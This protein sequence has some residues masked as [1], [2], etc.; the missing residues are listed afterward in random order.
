MSDESEFDLFELETAKL[1]LEAECVLGAEM[2]RAA[3][4]KACELVPGTDQE[5]RADYMRAYPEE[6]DANGNYCPQSPKRR[7]PL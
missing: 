2:V 4:A 6:F 7:R 5:L 1:L 3:W